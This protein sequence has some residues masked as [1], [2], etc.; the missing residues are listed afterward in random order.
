MKPTLDECAYCGG[1]L[2]PKTLSHYDYHWGEKTYRFE[3]VPA[4]VCAACGEV[5]FEAKVS[6]AMNKTVSGNPEPKRFD[7]IPVLAL[8]LTV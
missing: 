6:Q 7:Q 8:P 4:L 3:D 1:S 5:F 2:H